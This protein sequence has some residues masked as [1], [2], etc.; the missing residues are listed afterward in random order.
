MSSLGFIALSPAVALAGDE[1]ERRLTLSDAS[2]AIAACRAGAT[3]V[4]NL[5]YVEVD[6][7]GD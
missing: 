2:I 4:L 7:S 5:E 3:G 1:T 6:G